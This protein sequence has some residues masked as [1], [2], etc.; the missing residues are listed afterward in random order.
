M[1]HSEQPLDGDEA[2][3]YRALAHSRRRRVL[4]VLS[5]SD[6][7]MALA[8]LAAD[9]ASRES[10]ESEETADEASIERVQISLYHNHVPKLADASIV[11]FNA[12]KRTVS[13]D[14]S[15]RSRSIRNRLVQ[16]Q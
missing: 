14:D 15:E 5:E 3:V 9:I 12:S 13:L 7:P 10:K 4:D 2:S 6:S 1:T 11:E 16:T 8:D